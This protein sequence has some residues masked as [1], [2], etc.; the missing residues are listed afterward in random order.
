[1]AAAS[2][3]TRGRPTLFRRVFEIT[4][5]KRATAVAACATTRPRPPTDDYPLYYRPTPGRE[6]RAPLE[7]SEEGA[8]DAAG[9][10]LGLRPR[11][12]W[13]AACVRAV[14]RAG[15]RMVQPMGPLRLFLPMARWRQVPYEAATSLGV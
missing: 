15:V 1:M 8:R 7:S 3:A 12:P 11:P 14:R 5:R 4:T 9:S 6:E 2:E 13:H 10:R